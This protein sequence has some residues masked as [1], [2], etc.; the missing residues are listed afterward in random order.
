MDGEM[1][2]V[3]LAGGCVKQTKFGEDLIGKY[4]M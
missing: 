1:R 4:F 2:K 3:K